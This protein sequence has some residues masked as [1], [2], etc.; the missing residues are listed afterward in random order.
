MPISENGG[1]TRQVDPAREDPAAHGAGGRSFRRIAFASLIGTLIDGYDFVLYSVAA[2]LVFPKV[3]FPSLGGAAGTIASLATLGVAFVARPIGALLFGHFGDRLGRKRTLIW[4]I[5]GMGIG[6]TLM[7]LIPSANTIGVA[8]PILIV[9]LRAVQGLAVGGEWAGSVLFVTEHAPQQRR[10]LYSMFPQLGHSLP[11]ALSPAILLLVG[12]L[13][14]PESFIAWGWRV[15]FLAGAVLVIVGLYIRLKVEETPVFA[16]SKQRGQTGVP[17]LEAFK[18]QSWTMLRGIGVPLTTI[19][20]VYVAQS[21]V[22]NYGVEHLAL[23]RN[24]VLAVSAL[25]GLFYAAFTVLSAFLSDRAGRRRVIGGAHVLGVVW[26]V[27]LF[28]VLNLGTFPVYAAAL[29]V[30]MAIAGLAYGAVGAFLPEQFPTR[31]RYTAA[32]FSYQLT[33]VLGGGLAPLLAPVIISSY[34]TTT[35]GVVLGVLCALAAVCT[36][37]LKDRANESMDW[38]DPDQR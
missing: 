1:S 23:S 36:F 35:F 31:Y 20:F 10:G 33:G 13:S 3:F 37:S 32:G 6:T 12:V 24:Q 15:P 38:N 34:G 28:P 2:A 27:L 11:T 19:T 14:T 30:T 18:H 5:L 4:A 9:V 26:G 29:C 22:S 25:S 16:K 17:M 8:A 21:F 7:G